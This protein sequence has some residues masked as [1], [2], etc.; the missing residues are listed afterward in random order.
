MAGI[1][2]HDI[3]AGFRYDFFVWWPTVPAGY[4]DFTGGTPMLFAQDCNGTIALALTT[5]PNANGS[6]FKIQTTT[7]D[8]AN[9]LTIPAYA[10]LKAYLSSVDTTALAN[11]TL[12]YN[13]LFTPAAEQPFALLQGLF[14]LSP[15]QI[16]APESFVL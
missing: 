9:G 15:L 4:Y 11:L 7:F 3:I 12:N 8:A 2:N 1:K 10:S 6:Y 16:S 14:V 5:I 13:C